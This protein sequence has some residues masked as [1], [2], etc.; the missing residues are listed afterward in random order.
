MLAMP[1]VGPS[2]R[3]LIYR[4]FIVGILLLFIVVGSSACGP[5][6]EVKLPGNDG[7]LGGINS[8]SRF[9]GF[10]DDLGGLEILGPLLTPVFEQNGIEYQYT[11]TVMMFYN[12]VLARNQRYGLMPIGLEL[13]IS[14]PPTDM[15]EPGGHPIHESFLEIYNIVGKIRITGLPLTGGRYNP[16]RNGLEQYFENVGFYHLDSDQPGVVHLIEYGAWYC[17]SHCDYN[18]PYHAKPMFG[19]IADQPFSDAVQRLMD[20]NFLGNP[21]TEPYTARDGQ[22]EQIFENMV[23]IKADNRPGGIALRAIPTLLGIQAQH[24]ANIEVPGYFEEYILDNGGWEFTGQVITTYERKNDELYRQCFTNLCLD[25]FPNYVEG[26]QVRV[27]SLG[28]AYKDRFYENQIGQQ[29]PLDSG[30]QNIKLIVDEA[31]PVVAPSEQQVISVAVY[32][33]GQPVGGYEPILTLTLTQEDGNVHNYT[34]VFPPTNKDSGNSSLTINPID[35]PHGTRVRYE[36]CP[37]QNAP[38]DQCVRDDFLIWW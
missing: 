7:S 38:S 10:Y 37:L 36:V 13:G 22:L 34:F 11:S 5:I 19:A 33:D 18:G 26:Q 3:Y 4:K 30:T 16:E 14:E 29:Q 17:D 1:L 25:Y 12:P 28:Y 2:R 23:V 6:G 32:V 20:P 27:T 15:D 8:N 24:N 21:L 9:R 31:Y 35:A